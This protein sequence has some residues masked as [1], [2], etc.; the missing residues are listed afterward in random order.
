MRKSV[1]LPSGGERR[2][3]EC[4]K[5]MDMFYVIRDIPKDPAEL[6]VKIKDVSVMGK[7]NA[8]YAK[9]LV[10][11][12]EPGDD[13]CGGILYGEFANLASNCKSQELAPFTRFVNE[14]AVKYYGP[15]ARKTLDDFKG[16]EIGEKLEKLNELFK[17]G[18]GLRGESL[19]ESQMYNHV[20]DLDLSAYTFDVAA[21]MDAADKL[22]RSKL[23]QG[24]K[25]VG[26]LIFDLSIII[27][28]TRF[29]PEA[30]VVNIARGLKAIEE[31]EL[32]ERFR[33]INEYARFSAQM[34][35]K[36][37]YATILKH[38]GNLVDQTSD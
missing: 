12:A 15:C 34:L 22:G 20:K 11:Y 1:R 19:S 23:H 4:Q 27:R 32:T 38:F 6:L 8:N 30:N 25:S 14:Y 5:E 21:M 18:L 26:D 36:N 29:L 24:S 35:N 3:S 7:Y 2:S 31:E 33:L 10:A 9:R 37:C 28:R 13:V 16:E 17:A